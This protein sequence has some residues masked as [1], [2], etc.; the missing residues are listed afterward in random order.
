MRVQVSVSGR[1]MSGCQKWDF[2]ETA[3]GNGRRA[4]RQWVT[5]HFVLPC[6]PGCACVLVCVCVLHWPC[7][8]QLKWKSPGAPEQSLAN[9]CISPLS[10][11]PLQIW[12]PLQSLAF[13]STSVISSLSLVL[14]MLLWFAIRPPILT[15]GGLDKQETHWAHQLIGRTKGRLKP[16]IYLIYNEVNQSDHK[17]R[18]QHNHSERRTTQRGAHLSWSEKGTLKVSCTFCSWW[19]HWRLFCASMHIIY[20]YN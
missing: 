8:L 1:H 14:G 5:H 4:M 10:K 16:I 3:V 18:R 15:S 12:F 19:K 13:P 17:G 20:A 11:L 7:Y 2:D 6:T 9:T